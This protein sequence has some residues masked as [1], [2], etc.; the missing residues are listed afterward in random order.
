MLYIATRI[1]HGSQISRAACIDPS[2][3]A[4]GRKIVFY[5]IYEGWINCTQIHLA[6]AYAPAFNPPTVPVTLNNIV[7]ERASILF[8]L[9]A[10]YSQLATAEDRSTSEGIKRAALKYQVRLRLLD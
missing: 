9:A 7:F 1:P 10:L 4:N 8:N 6:I 3:N 5:Q 2:E